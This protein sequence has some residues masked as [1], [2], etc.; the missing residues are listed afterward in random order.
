MQEVH[1]SPRRLR[2]LS[3]NGRGSDPRLSCRKDQWIQVESQGVGRSCLIGGAGVPRLFDP[4]CFYCWTKK[5]FEF[6]PLSSIA[7]ARKKFDREAIEGTIATMNRIYTTIEAAERCETS[8]SSISRAAKR[9]GVGVRRTDGRL[10]GLT[11]QDLKAVVKKLRYV[12]GNPN[13]IARKK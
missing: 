1:L 4:R 7:S 2:R 9:A 11:E 13:W 6:E 10:V 12:A 8:P 5:G 3:Q